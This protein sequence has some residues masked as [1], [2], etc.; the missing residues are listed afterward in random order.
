MTKKVKNKHIDRIYK[1]FI[2]VTNN[3]NNPRHEIEFD[4]AFF[5]LNTICLMVGTIYFL[6]VKEY[7]WIGVL[8][9]E[10]NWALDNMRHNR[11]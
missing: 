6:V 3:E 7:G 5:T 11:S 2:W 8:L 10:Y 9:I 4:I 1:W